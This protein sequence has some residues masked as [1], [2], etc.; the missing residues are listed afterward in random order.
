MIVKPNKGDRWTREEM[1]LVLNLYFKMSYGQ[2]N[3]TNPKVR[4]LA[5][6]MGRSA[7]SISFRLSNF[8]SCDPILQARGIS[9]L[10]A[11]I[12]QCQPYWDEFEKNKDALVFESEKILAEYEDVSL[13]DKY[14]E[15]LKDIPQ[16]L[17]GKTRLQE[18]KTRVNQ[19]FFRQIVLANYG[20]R[21]ALTGIDIPDLL[22][23][24]HIIPWANDTKERL[25]PANGICLSALYDKAFDK[26]Y[27]SFD[28][29][30]K[31]LLSNNIEDKKDRDYYAKYFMTIKGHKIEGYRKY[32]PNPEFLNWHR[33]HIFKG[34]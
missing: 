15:D 7:S 9:G 3:H 19:S 33:Q 14:E 34:L 25:N 16:G 10:N 12:K 22:I 8:A 11:H 1:I 4:E 17:V 29:E 2:M 20:G 26:G 28:N 13:E 30:G 21:C 5:K 27:M 23:A 32:A 24:S 31:V 18:V 6:L